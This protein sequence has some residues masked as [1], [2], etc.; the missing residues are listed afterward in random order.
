FGRG[1]EG[2][3]LKIFSYP[4]YPALILLRIILKYPDFQED[5][6]SSWVF[7]EWHGLH[8]GCQFD[9]SQKSA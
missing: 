9:S 5:R 6:I 4:P 8:N 2:I 1:L 3:G 7:A